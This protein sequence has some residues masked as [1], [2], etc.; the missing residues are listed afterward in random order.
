MPKNQR[1]LKGIVIFLGILIIAMVII[2]IV[3]SVMKYNDQKDAEV[4]LVEKYQNKMVVKSN[5]Q[6]PFIRDLTLKDGEEILSAQS[7]D[8]G[9]LLNIG[10]QNITKTIILIDYQGKIIA[11]INVVKE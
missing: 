7:S 10:S 6:V 3:A 11:T 8:K 4:A 9:I 2:L 5:S 1:I